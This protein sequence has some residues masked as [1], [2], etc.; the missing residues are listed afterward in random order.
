MVTLFGRG[1]ETGAVEELAARARASAGGALVVRGEPGIGKSLLLE[2][3]AGPAAEHGMAVL[4]AAGVQ[5]ETRLAFAGLHQLLGPL[6]K[7][8]GRLPARQREA[9]LGAFG[10]AE[11]AGPEF[12]MIALAALNLLSDAAAR[13]PL[14]ALV[15]DVQW[16]DGP[17]VDVL[18]FAARRLAAE[19]VALLVAGRTGYGAAEDG[20]DVPSLLLDRLD[21]RDSAALLADRA[22]SLAA[23]DRERVLAEATGNP[24]A[25]VELPKA[26]ERGR[27]APGSLFLPLTTRLERAFAARAAEL[28]GTARAALLVAA[29]DD[30]GTVT[31][32]LAALRHLRPGIGDGATGALEEAARAGLAE[33]EGPVVRFRHPL[34]RSAVYQGAAAAD[35]SAAHTALARVLA[36]DPDR[37]AWHRAAA[38]DRTDEP[39]AAELAAVA[40]R[41]CARGAITV[42]VAA[43][44]RAAALSAGPARRGGLLLRAAE[45][46]FEQGR[47]D[48]VTRLLGTAGE[49][50]LGPAEQV[51]AL[52]LRE[53]VE[54]GLA[55]G[56]VRIGALVTA[57]ERAVAGGEPGFGVHLLRAAAL[58]CWWSGADRGTRGRVVAAAERLPVPPDDPEL[59]F[60]LASAAPAECGALVV[61]RLSRP[62]VLHA[63][64]GA[65]A[66]MLGTAA[67][68]V[69]AYDL[70]GAPLALSAATLRA[71]GRLGVLTQTLTSQAFQAF[72]GGDWE[73]A[74]AAADEAQRLAADTGMPRWA[75]GARIAAGMLAGVRGDRDAGLALLA[76]AERTVVPMANRSNLAFLQIARGLV[77]LG[78]GRHA[79]AYGQLRRAFDPADPYHH[80]FVRSWG[81]GELAEAA[82]ATGHREQAHE[83]VLEMAEMAALTPAPLLH[84]GLRYARALLAGEAE[85]EERFGEALAADLERWPFARAR[86]Q[87]AYGS[88][89]R[90]RRRVADSRAPLRAAREA[91][92]A[93]GALP[94]GERARHELRAAGE[95]SDRRSPAARDQ[96]SPQ[97]LQI[98]RMAAAGLTNREIGEQLYLSHRTVSTHLYRLFPKLGVTSRAQLRDVLG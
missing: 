25:L 21:A 37:R 84:I 54:D 46:A 85:A 10:M 88:W 66:R 96:L 4:R 93:L 48:Q 22:P 69:G 42:A 14:L 8:A 50:A 45:L 49:L 82:V 65:A 19:P 39:V 9:L 81:I 60:L 23:V 32:V 12:F 77:L 13:R 97:E 89:L 57:A 64:D 24:L 26:L 78:D 40:D 29:A 1:R 43:L 51:R 27:T 62:S 63:T 7:D 90:R 35:R 86:L 34:V 74:A 16:L 31:E 79:D 55:D 28:S 11:A 71:Q 52:W 83:A 33:I 15:D 94:W 61:E 95:P 67:T 58:R 68:C 20:W 80:P 98:A 53:L 76:E 38:L 36:A 6:L 73:L 47:R 59:L 2:R 75:A 5:A 17:T 70:A 91:F 3:A 30:D 87:L 41:A 92:D 72:H 44:E 56:T 18:R